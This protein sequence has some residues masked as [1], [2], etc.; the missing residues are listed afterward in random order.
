MTP[1]FSLDDYVDVAE[2]IVLFK[3]AHPEGSL[4]S[5][6][7]ILELGDRTFVVCEAHAFRSP[8]D[9]KPGHGIAWEPF[10]GATPY[11]RESELMNAQTSAWGRAIV[12]VGIVA[13][14][15]IASRQEVQARHG[16]DEPAAKSP[17]SSAPTEPQLKLLKTL[18]TQ[19]H[20]PERTLRAMLNTVGAADVAIETGWAGRLTKSQAS[21]MIE[22]FKNGVL[23]DPEAQDISTDMPDWQPPAED[24]SDVP[25][26]VDEQT[27]LLESAVDTSTKPAN[28]IDAEMA[29]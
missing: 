11:T 15:S 29:A 25:F 26:G 12:A 5:K 24:N 16:A 23:P 17:R 4:T 7:Q 8:D 9:T 18:V 22:I 19:H 1:K 27:E 13:N 10:P 21:A 14:R 20:P 3:E 6:W 28:A 2:R